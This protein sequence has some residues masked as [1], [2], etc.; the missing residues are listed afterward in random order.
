MP[1]MPGGDEGE[2][3]EE[4]AESREEAKEQVGH[5]K[6][7]NLEDNDL[8][9]SGAIEAASDKR[10][11]EAKSRILCKAEGGPKS[12][13]SKIQREGCKRPNHEILKMKDIFSTIS[14]LH[15]NHQMLKKKAQM[16]MMTGLGLERRKRTTIQQQVREFNE[17]R[18]GTAEH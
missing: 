14:I 17:G 8:N 12:R 11:R 2:K 9:L 5:S 15:R 13:A 1:K 18:G 7:K 3:K 16:R 10:S 6:N 4:T